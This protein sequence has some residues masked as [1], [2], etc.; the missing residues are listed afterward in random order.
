[1]LC[2]SCLL[3]SLGAA[4]VLP[5]MVLSRVVPTSNVFVLSLK[6]GLHRTESAGGH[7]VRRAPFS[8]G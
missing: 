1:V 3:F 5:S 8:V 4:V 6:T 2:P 7:I